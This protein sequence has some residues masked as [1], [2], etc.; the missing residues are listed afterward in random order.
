MKKILLRVALATLGLFIAMSIGGW[1]ILR[2]SLPVLD[3]RVHAKGVLS[4][5]T[6][7]RDAVGAVTVNGASRADVAY[8]LGYAHGQDRFFQMD[9]LRRA[10]AGE[11]SALLGGAT[12]QT[13]RMLRVHRLRS[14]ARAVVARAS[15]EQRLVLDAYTA[16]VNAGLGSLRARPLEYLLLGASPEAWRAEDSALCVLAMFVQLQDPD[17]HTKV[18]R[19]LVSGALPDV[20][21]RFVYAEASDWD[22]TLD[23]TPAAA[24]AMP[25]EADYDLAKVTPADDRGRTR[26][27]RE[28]ELIGSNNWVVSGT[29]TATGA[30]LVANDMHLGIRVPNTWYRARLHWQG[31]GG[32]GADISGVTLP[33][34]PTVVA[35]SNGHVA[36]G[37]TN[38]YGDYQELVTVVSDPADAARYLDAEGSHP[39]G[40]A[41][42]RITVRGGAAV[43]IDVLT[44]RFGPVVGQ[45]GS[46]RRLALQ[47]TAHDPQAVNFEMLRMEQIRDVP[48]ALDLAAQVGI[49]AQNLVVGDRDGHIG[50]TIAG[51]IPKRRAA[52]VPVRLSTDPAAGFDGWLAASDHPRITDP[53]AG[54]LSTANAR[55]VGGEFLD[56]IGDGGYDRGAR[57]HQV[58]H[59]LAERGDHL[60]PADML[61][62]QLDDRAIFLERWHGLLKDL[63]DDAAINGD[64]RRAEV[65]AVLATWSGHAGI[66][67]AAYRIVRAFRQEVEHRMFTALIAP[68]RAS[69]PGF[70]FRPPASF[71]GP[72]WVLVTARPAHLLPPGHHDWRAF[73]LSAL[74]GAVASLP[75]ECAKL[76]ECTWG[77]ANVSRIRHPLSAAVPALAELLDVPPEMLPGDN[78][79]PRVQGTSFGAS[80][81]FAVSPGHEADGY[82]EMPGGQSGHPLSPYFR[83]GHERWAHGMKAPF[84]PGTAEHRLT[85]AP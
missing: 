82:F 1:L 21:A 47:W 25:A 50:W 17:A 70:A 55:V 83:A 37:F 16:G 26:R 6:V 71:E 20:A 79:M 3:G 10:A 78:D 80:E 39:F 22:A 57:A 63:L 11:L 32:E 31:N 45:D 74:D 67:D 27:A 81:R 40:H 34:A 35:G 7:E 73:L 84:L 36:W 61:A 14:V 19:A 33:G 13:D 51:Q 5:V 41:R 43:E 85:L 28:R 8:G 24:P 23:H 62:V 60:E 52:A 54:Q 66:D 68:A 76:A 59:D 9:L 38:S 42:E 2:A 64:T 49:P 29:R 4:V 72:L 30:A 69:S 53:T 46:G 15:P 12:V 75:A 77:R 56:R 48:Q 18:Q 58:A 65:A 44:T